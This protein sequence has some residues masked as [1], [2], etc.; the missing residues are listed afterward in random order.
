[1]CP[2]KKKN[3]F[4]LSHGHTRIRELIRR[5]HEDNIAITIILYY[6]ISTIFIRIWWAFR[7]RWPHTLTRELQLNGLCNDYNIIGISSQEIWEVFSVVVLS[8][9]GTACL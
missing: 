1:M 7:L 4:Y 5:R 3:N 6:N 2:G 8:R 9:P